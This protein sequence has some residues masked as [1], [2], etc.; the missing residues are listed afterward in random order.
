MIY[1]LLKLLHVLSIILWVG[2]MAFTLFALRPALGALEPP[3]RIRLMHDVLARFFNLVLVAA[4]L[5]LVSGLWMIG[6]VAKAASQSGA[7][8][9]MPISWTVM[10]T[11]GI[12]MI[13]LFGHIRFA[14]FKRVRRALQAGDWAAGAAALEAIRTWVGLNFILGVAT[15]CIILLTP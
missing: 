5:T 11:L 12:V 2:G 4:L 7:G 15:V 9:D 1:N 6:R 13:A 8:F 3:A 14:L 10:A